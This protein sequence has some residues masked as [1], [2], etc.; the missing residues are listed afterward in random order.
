MVVQKRRQA[1][2][3]CLMPVAEQ[4]GVGAIYVKGLKA[5]RSMGD[6]A[7]VLV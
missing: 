5:M 2:C 7:E 6:G 4:K 1:G 3:Q